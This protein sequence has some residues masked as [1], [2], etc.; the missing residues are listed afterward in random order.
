MLGSLFGQRFWILAYVLLAAGMWLPGDYR[1]TKPLIPWVLGTILF[2]TSLRVRFGTVVSE[3]DSRRGVARLAIL[4]LV[5]LVALPLIP[6]GL[7][8]ALAPE[9]ALGVL[10]VSMMPG[11]MSSATLADLYR[12]NLGLALL[13]IL[14]T[15]VLCPLTIPLLLQVLDPVGGAPDMGLMLRQAGYILVLLMT[16]FALAQMCWRIAPEFVARHR[17]FWQNGGIATLCLLVFVSVAPNRDTW[18]EVPPAA[19]WMP[20]ALTFAASALFIACGL[21]SRL[22]LARADAVSFGCA[23]IYMNNGL[24]V[25]FAVAFYPGNAHMLLPSIMM[26]IPMMGS[27]ALYGWYLQR[28]SQTG[29]VAGKK[30]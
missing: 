16:P 18:S 20:F 5:K 13:I 9:W 30:P 29:I 21:V 10:L 12:G 23:C 17:K 3:I 26:Q 24:A 15:S 6:Y 25:A 28:K 7:A 8:L 14:G 4:S 1:W 11:G 2:F 19:L 22:M 27:T